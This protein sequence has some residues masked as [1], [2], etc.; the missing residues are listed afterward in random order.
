V[1]VRARVRVRVGLRVR[2]RARF[3]VSV[4]LG[5]CVV[6]RGLL[7]EER[8]QHQLVPEH[9]AGRLRRDDIRVPGEGWG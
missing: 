7:V 1:R 4:R 6:H 5:E 3:R 9:H 2:V 8:T